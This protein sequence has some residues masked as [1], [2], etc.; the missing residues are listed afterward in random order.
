MATCRVTLECSRVID[1]STDHTNTILNTSKDAI[2]SKIKRQNSKAE[3]KKEKRSECCG[4]RGDY[5]DE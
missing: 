3:L 5:L 4:S 2:L 1:I